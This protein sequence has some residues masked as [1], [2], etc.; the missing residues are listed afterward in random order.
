MQKT[1]KNGYGEKIHIKIVGEETLIHHEDAMDDFKSL[2]WVLENIILS[3]EEIQDIK[4]TI[5]ELKNMN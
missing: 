4:D 2:E 3:K 5:D 1:I